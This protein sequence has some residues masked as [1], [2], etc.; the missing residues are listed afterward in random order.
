M[1][2][3]MNLF[4]AM[5]ILCLGRYDKVDR[6]TMIIAGIVMIVNLTYILYLDMKDYD[7]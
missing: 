1:L 3:A 2:H 7:D 5:F 6:T 4:F